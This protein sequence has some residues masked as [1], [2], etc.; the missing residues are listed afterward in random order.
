MEILCKTFCLCFN[1][2]IEYT[3]YEDAMIV[4][5]CRTVLSIPCIMK[6]LQENLTTVTTGESE[7]NLIDPNVLK[8]KL[9]DSGFINRIYVLLSNVERI[10]AFLQKRDDI[11]ILICF[12][13]ISSKSLL[14]RLGKLCNC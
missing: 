10:Q 12:L 4:D 14:F 7:S 2:L 8:S 13:G 1:S 9:I 6:L 5:F 11:N 3:N